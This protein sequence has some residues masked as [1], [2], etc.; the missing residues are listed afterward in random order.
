MLA[1]QREL[2]TLTNTQGEVLKTITKTLDRKLTDLHNMTELLLKQIDRSVS[3]S[4][5]AVQQLAVQYTASQP[6]PH[7][8]LMDAAPADAVE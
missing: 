6:Q 5:E 1:V 7:Y 4:S 2:L 8:D 3:Q